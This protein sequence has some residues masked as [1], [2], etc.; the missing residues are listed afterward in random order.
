MVIFC[1]TMERNWLKTRSTLSTRPLKKSSVSAA[2]RS[3]ADWT[4][5]DAGGAGQVA[6][7]GKLAPAEIVAAL[8][9]HDQIA[10]LVGLARLDLVLAP[11]LGRTTD[12]AVEAATQA[13]IRGDGH[14][15]NAAAVALLQQGMRLAPG[16]RGHL[17]GDL[18]QGAGV[19]PRGH[20]RV[21]RPAQLGR[22]HQLHGAGD[23][24]RRLY[25]RD[26]GADGFQGWHGEMD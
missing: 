23:L 7:H 26:P 3:L 1:E 8:A 10:D 2:A 19:G 5:V 14:H 17:G 9:A 22:R 4:A 16:A 11:A 18:G 24:L 6:L 12:V 21:L 15:G 20:D 25:R 13:A